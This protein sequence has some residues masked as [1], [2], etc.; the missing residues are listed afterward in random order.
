[1][2]Y[3][4]VKGCYDICGQP[5]EE[6]KSPH[7]WLWIESKVNEIASLYGFEKIVTP[8]FEHTEVFT[9]SMGQSSDVVSKEMYSFQDK[10][11]R[12][13]SLRPEMTA[14]VVRAFIENSL[15][16]SPNHRFYYFGP[17]WRYDRAQKGRYRQFYQFG[18]EI[19]GSDAPISD[20]ETIAMLLDFYKSLGLKNTTLLL[21]SIGDKSTRS[22]FGKALKEHLSPHVNSL[23]EDSKRRFETNPLR[24]LDSKDPKDHKLCEGAPTITD[25]LSEA[26]KDHFHQVCQGLDTLGISY[27]INTSLVRGLD[28]YCDT[29]FEVISNDDVAAQNTIGAGG[30][31]NGLVKEM[32][33]PDIPGI[34][35]A[36]G[37]ERV[38]QSL[39]RQN[40]SVPTRLGPQYY[41]IPLSER[42]LRFCLKTATEFRQAG[43]SAIIHQKNFNVKK[44]LQ[45]ANDFAS[46]YAVIIGDDELDKKIIKIKN[47]HSR[48]EDEYTLSDLLES[49][50]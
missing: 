12:S 4:K 26:G 32:G 2:T 11:D 27:T 43:V 35:F 16:Q 39:L 20:I 19:F 30:R 9:R 31:Y 46:K 47:L 48:E 1:M 40:A 37:I 24:I 5:D 10:G 3:K 29:V 21:N 41:F 44:G 7:L 6:W 15:A 22:A 34:G 17:C 50:K 25:F 8:V 13:L 36:T 28:Y 42:A 18:I 14:P 23:S 49:I 38:L 33:G 45:A